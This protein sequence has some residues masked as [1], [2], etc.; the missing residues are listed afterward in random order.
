LQQGGSFA[1]RAGFAVGAVRG[2]AFGQPGLVGVEGGE[3]DVAGVGVGDERDPLLAWQQGDV[4]LTL[5]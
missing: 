5:R 4:F 1:G 3:G 2:G